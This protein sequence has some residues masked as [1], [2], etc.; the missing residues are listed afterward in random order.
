MFSCELGP[1]PDAHGPSRYRTRSG[2]CWGPLLQVGGQCPALR[3]TKDAAGTAE[4]KTERRR[5]APWVTGDCASADRTTLL[6]RSCPGLPASPWKPDG[7][8]KTQLS[9]QGDLSIPHTECVC[10][11]MGHELSP[12]LSYSL[13]KFRQQRPPALPWPEG[14]RSALARQAWFASPARLPHVGT[15]VRPRPAH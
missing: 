5:Q 13:W 15:S 3:A 7:F 1:A 14:P 11:N 8:P 12:N 10:H 6:A 2:P 4:L 9:L